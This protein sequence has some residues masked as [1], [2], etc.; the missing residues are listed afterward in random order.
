MAESD[1]EGATGA[2]GNR[3]ELVTRPLAD[4]SGFI[5]V[6]WM[7]GWMDGWTNGQMGNTGGSRPPEGG[8]PPKSITG[9]VP[10]LSLE[11]LAELTLGA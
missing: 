10:H 11:G 7:D 1:R 8:A 3:S 5:T 6:R 9:T 2:G 4:V